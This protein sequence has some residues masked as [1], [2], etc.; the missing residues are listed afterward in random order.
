MIMFNESKAPEQPAFFKTQYEFTR[1]I[2]NPNRHPQPKDIETRRLNIYH[3]LFYN[4]V[5]GFM[6][7][8]FPVIKSIL[9][10]DLWHTLIHD[11]FEKHHAKSPFFK[12]MPRE[13]LHYLQSEREPQN[14][15]PIFLLELAHYEWAEL[16]ISISDAKELACNPD[17]DLLNHHPLISSTA[18]VLHYHF[19]VHLIKETFQPEQPGETITSIIL[20]RLQDDNVGFIEINTV[21]ARVL[22][23]IEEMTEASGREILLRVADEINHNNPDLVIE[24]GL[25]ILTDLRQRGI[26]SGT[27]E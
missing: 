1:Y 11:Y 15:D 25:E 2:R 18:W 21:T 26:I 8:T 13:F 7:T 24:S 9:H 14:T 16:A 3:E 6:A 10:D 12:E 20:Y 4:N 27:Q 17:G 5:E 22:Q 19:P 23:L